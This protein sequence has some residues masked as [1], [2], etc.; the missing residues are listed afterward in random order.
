MIGNF[1]MQANFGSGSGS[2]SIDT[3]S[4]SIGGNDL[5]IGIG[6]GEFSGDIVFKNDDGVLIANGE[7][8]GAFSKYYSYYN[9]SEVTGVYY[10]T[11]GSS[12]YAVG[13]FVGESQ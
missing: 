9:D 2:I 10:D 5:N 11:N 1:T 7:V 13:A 12:P 8:V 4:L 6:T 3:G